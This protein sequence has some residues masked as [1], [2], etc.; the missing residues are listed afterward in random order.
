M[1]AN[2]MVCDDCWARAVEWAPVRVTDVEP[3]PCYSCGRI[4]A[5]GIF[6]RVRR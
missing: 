4:T 2:A 5:S 1:W 6:V 3:R